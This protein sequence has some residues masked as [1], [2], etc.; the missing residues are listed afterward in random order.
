MQKKDSTLEK[1]SIMCDQIIDYVMAK[2]G[3]PQTDFMDVDQEHV[4]QAILGY[5]HEHQLPIIEHLITHNIIDEHVLISLLQRIESVVTEND[6]DEY[7]EKRLREIE[8]HE[9]EAVFQKM[10]D[11]FTHI[12]YVTRSVAKHSKLREWDGKVYAQHVI[13]L[14]TT[15]LIE[16][17]V[18]TQDVTKYSRFIVKYW[19]HIVSSVAEE[20]QDYILE[21]GPSAALMLVPFVERG[22]FYQETDTGDVFPVKGRKRAL[23]LREKMPDSKVKSLL[24]MSDHYSYEEL[25]ALFDKRDLLSIDA[26]KRLLTMCLDDYGLKLFVL[27]YLPE[28]VERGVVR[29]QRVKEQFAQSYFARK[30]ELYQTNDLSS[31]EKKLISDAKKINP[32]F[33]E[34]LFYSDGLRSTILLQR[35]NNLR[36]D[37]DYIFVRHIVQNFKEYRSYFET[38]DDIEDFIGEHILSAGGFSTIKLLNL[39]AK[40]LKKIKSNLPPSDLFRSPEDIKVM[41]ELFGETYTLNHF[42]RSQSELV[43]AYNATLPFGVTAASDAF[44]ETTTREKIDYYFNT[45]G[46]F[47]YLL[48][49]SALND[50][51]TTD[52]VKVL[53][54]AA[55]RA[56]RL[57]V[58]RYPLLRDRLSNIS[59]SELKSIMISIADDFPNLIVEFNE[60]FQQALGRDH[61]VTYLKK[62]LD[63]RHPYFIYTLLMSHQ[64]G[65]LKEHTHVLIESFKNDKKTFVAAGFSE[66]VSATVALIKETVSD[67]DDRFELYSNGIPHIKTEYGGSLSSIIFDLPGNAVQQRQ[68]IYEL[69]SKSKDGSYELLYFI[70]KLQKDNTDESLARQMTDEFLDFVLAEKPDLVFWS[71]DF[72]KILSEQSESHLITY[73]QA[74]LKLLPHKIKEDPSV[75]MSIGKLLNDEQLNIYKRQM[76]PLAFD[77]T[78]NN[79]SVY[80]LFDIDPRITQIVEG[81]NVF[82]QLNDEFEGG[83]YQEVIDM[84]EGTEFYDLFAESLQ[85]RQRHMVKK[86]GLQKEVPTTPDLDFVELANRLQILNHSDLLKKHAVLI[87]QQLNDRLLYLLELFVY[88]GLDLTADSL[89]TPLQAYLETRIS[90]HLS[91]MLN[92]SI[93]DTAGLSRLDTPTLRAYVTYYKQ[94][95]VGNDTLTDAFGVQFEQ[96]A[97]GTFNEWRAWGEANPDAHS[98]ELMLDRLKEQNLVPSGIT[99]EQYHAWIKTFT[100]SFE[101]AM[102]VYDSNVRDEISTVFRQALDHR[103]MTVDEYAMIENPQLIQ[104][105]L[106]KLLSDDSKIR[107]LEDDIEKAQKE[108]ADAKKVAADTMLSEEERNDIL[109]DPRRNVKKAKYA[110]QKYSKDVLRVRLE[111][112]KTL[113]LLSAL[114]HITAAAIRTNSIPFAG[115]FITVDT[116]FHQLRPLLKE[117]PNLYNDILQ[118]KAKVDSYRTAIGTGGTKHNLRLTDEVN[119]RVLIRVGSDPVPTC[120]DFSSLSDYNEALIA[121]VVDP[122]NKVIQMY[123]D[124]GRYIARAQLRLLEQNDGTPEVFLEHVYSVNSNPSIQEAF[125]GYVQ[126]KADSMNVQYKSGNPLFSRGSRAPYVYTDAGGGKVENGVFTV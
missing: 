75:I 17:I 48:D 36:D 16:Y 118:I 119:P 2:A 70:Q 89:E 126:Q 57:F 67:K 51:T 34:N 7:E 59:A 77:R 26:Y 11:Q 69:A 35:I 124:V 58:V 117:R 52:Q 65:K 103:H 33:D 80:S 31:R 122:S 110:K 3:E 19:E 62:Y 42:M 29:E 64:R 121:T 96:L 6:A 95:C 115:T 72:L 5:P 107:M 24:S 45:S 105:A 86:H 99:I 87:R 68:I 41:A 74:V 114:S 98:K 8:G 14:L 22:I 18:K 84:L 37:R 120:Q 101:G 88:S 79:H 90:Q 28:A 91:D 81:Y 30:I 104:E 108:F 49:L 25:V 82:E 39:S 100:Q 32:D 56:P 73:T 15:K 116:I 123:D 47:H 43:T 76:L 63:Q 92:I 60:I 61:Y 83:Y 78:P 102:N 46:A 71:D 111:G 10:L 109:S 21:K 125:D 94:T 9:D 1:A 54:Y 12:P 53:Q 93:S 27:P 50:K 44:T 20:L 66:S 38:W 113:K 97:A 23:E 106:D 4:T 40:E 55:Q 13:E 112:I 85:E